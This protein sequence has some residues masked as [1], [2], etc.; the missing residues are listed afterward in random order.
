MLRKR[1]LDAAEQLLLA[2]GVDGFRLDAVAAEAGVSKG[3][4]L[5]HF[6]SKQALIDGVLL[7]R[8]DEFDA[9]LP[10]PGDPPGIFTRTWLEAAVPPVE[11]EVGRTGDQIVVVL[12][13]A[14]GGGPPSMDIL[15][16]R[17]EIWQQKLAADGLDPVVATLVRVAADGWWLSH[18][19]NLAPPRGDLYQQ[20]RVQILNMLPQ[21]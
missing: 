17:Y 15:R 6:R 3:G 20:M 12:L 18:V 14:L 8:L 1:V 7:R 10:E 16:E 4:L 9:V 11:P 13:S 19:L 2:K 21:R 5:H